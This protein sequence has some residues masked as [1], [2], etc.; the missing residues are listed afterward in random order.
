MSAESKCN[1]QHCNGHISFPSEMAGQTTNCPH[2]QLETL[3]FI[4]QMAVSPK[5]SAPTSRGGNKPVLFVVAIVLLAVIGMAVIV[6]KGA[7]QNSQKDLA[8][9][10]PVV[11]AFGYKLGDKLTGTVE[12]YASIKDMPPF[13]SL[14]LDT[15]ADGH[16]CIITLMGH[17]DE[18]EA[19]DSKKRLV[20]ILSEKYGLRFH[21]SDGKDEDYDFG[22]IDQTAH[23]KILGGNYFYLD[24]S[25]NKL[26]D[27]YFGE[28]K[29]IREKEDADKKAAMS[30]GL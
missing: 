15:T 13:T 16:I 11:G 30:K 23:L 6:G 29:I 8:N 5:L 14:H 12:D 3:L 1:C 28:Q 10:K 20:S 4:P 27:I 7:K 9:L 22:T 26:R 2:C 19:Y 24:Y 17:T 18:F 25:D 21:K